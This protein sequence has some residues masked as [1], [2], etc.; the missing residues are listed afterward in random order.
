MKKN[1]GQRNNRKNTKNSKMKSKS[2]EKLQLQFKLLKKELSMN[3]SNNF[4]DIIITI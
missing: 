4:D 3:G 2:T 1:K